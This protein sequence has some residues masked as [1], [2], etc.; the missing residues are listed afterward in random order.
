MP[1]YDENMRGVLFKNDRKE[2]D[3]QPDYTGFINVNKTE[4]R[5]AAWI[6]TSQKDGYSKFMSLQVSERQAQP[7]KERLQPD[8][9]DIPF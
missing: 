7:R 5:L 1:Q 4:Y 2:R 3:D 6:K 8:K 9:D